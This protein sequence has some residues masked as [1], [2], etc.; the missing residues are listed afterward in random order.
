M[1]RSFFLFP[2]L[3]LSAFGACF[4]QSQ[5]AA[6]I[7]VLA[8]NSGF[9]TY[10]G[11]ML[12]AEGYNAYQEAS[13][14]QVTR[15]VLDSFDIV[16]L[17][18]TFLTPAQTIMV[19]EYVSNGGNLIAFRPDKQ[20]YPILGITAKGSTL[21]EG[22][23]K[24]DTATDLGK[25]L[26][27][28][29]IQFHGLADRCALNGGISIATL[30]DG[31]STSTGEPAV[32]FNRFGNGAALAFVYNLPQSIVYTRQGNP[33]WAAQERDNITGIRAAEMFCGMGAANW[34]DPAKVGLNQADEQMRLL[35]HAIEKMSLS[36]KPLP[37]FW[38]FPALHRSVVIAT[39]DGENSPESEI[40]Q[41]LA[42]V[43]SK[44]ARMTIYLKSSAYNADSVAAWTAAGHELSIHPDDTREATRPVYAN[45]D[46]EVAL[47]VQ[48]FS[49]AYGLTPRTVRNHWIVW[50]GWTGQAQIDARH[51]L[52]FDCNYYHYQVG[53]SYG[54]FLG[55][56]GNY[57]GSGLIM[58]FADSSGAIIPVYQSNT[59]VPDEAWA[60]NIYSSFKTILD[61]SLDSEAYT[62][63]NINFHP[64]RQASDRKGLT[65]ILDYCNSRNVPVWTAQKMLSFLQMKDGASFKNIVWSGGRLTFTL[66]A[67]LAGQDLTFM[68]P[69]TH[70]N[71]DSL[72]GIT[73][74][75]LSQAYTLSIIK[76][77][78]YAMATIAAGGSYSIV[79]SYKPGSSTG[80]GQ[81][82]QSG[83][84]MLVGKT[85]TAVRIGISPGGLYSRVR[86]YDIGGRVVF[87]HTLDAQGECQW[88]I[89]RAQ[90]GIYIVKATKSNGCLV[91]TVL[92]S[93]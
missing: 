86:V 32:I 23:I 36:K 16:I 14:S 28:Q 26:V 17:A 68:I 39:G 20:L 52:G 73:Q 42:L 13:L 25:K 72:T 47:K 61:Q 37:R 19:Q 4:G 8:T 7:L 85:P 93:K 27:A 31:P 48:Q 78:R 87:A 22:Y 12:K 54:S 70:G 69:A 45:M 66:D 51:G 9:G 11:E 90:A 34:N 58:K 60:P 10:T 79:A 83:N 2:A 88:P 75:G 77:T 15:T 5:R 30:H 40:S 6:P 84:S 29:T 43:H 74:N 38:Y 67:P 44:G 49:Q 65:D 91:K 82:E 62:A 55:E 57:T 46:S 21:S 64:D 80:M 76:G 89:N 71:A 53:S 33:K 3:L 35:S 50:V 56:P 59:Q 81:I 24:V 18:E 1:K 63:I 41:E 92:I